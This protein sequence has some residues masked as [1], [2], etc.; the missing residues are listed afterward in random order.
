MNTPVRAVVVGINEYLDGRS[1]NEA[2]LQFA[3]N[4][5]EA[6]INV[7]AGSSTLQL[8]QLYFYRGAEASR[9]NIQSGLFDVFSNRLPGQNAIALFYFAGHGLFNIR[10]HST[11]LCGYDTDF[12]DPNDGGIRLNQIYEL[13]MQSS[14]ECTIVILDACY[15]GGVIDNG[16]FYHETPAERAKKAIEA[17]RG[18]DGKT[19]AIFA[20]CRTN[21]KAREDAMHRGGIYTDRLLKG[22]RDGEARGDDGTVT[23][24][25]LA[26]YVTRNFVGDRQIPRVSIL[27]SRPIVLWKGSAPAP[28]PVV[29]EEPKPYIGITFDP[30]TSRLPGTDRP[31][32]KKKPKGFR[33]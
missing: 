15:S 3:Q 11:W 7:L 8:E 12:S 21:Q 2:R 23:L 13:I 14:A 20:S 32:Q 16:Y 1:H 31:S 26:D 19:M 17:L 6:I 30:G 25:G 10:D 29:A 24:L 28:R 27:G 33:W 18:P 5:A 9:K 4:D 22:W